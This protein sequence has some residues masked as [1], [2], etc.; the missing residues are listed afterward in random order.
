VGRELAFSVVRKDLTIDTFSAGGP[1]GQ[2]QNTSNT[3][4]RI[5]HKASGATGVA[6]DSRSQ[7]QNMKAA[8]RRMTQ[9]SKF[10]VWTN[11]M[12]LGNPLPPEEQVERDMHPSNLLIMGYENGRPV[13]LK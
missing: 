3:G 8:L 7:H 5:T 6:R 10:K 2:H 9:H 12:L 4:V 1:G 11:R 13:V